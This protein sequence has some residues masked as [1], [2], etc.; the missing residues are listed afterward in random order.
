MA[1]AGAAWGAY[2]LVGRS[3]RD[4]IVA[5][6]RGFLW[7]TALALPIVAIGLGSAVASVEGVVL[8]VVCGAITS[9]LGY[10]VWYRALPRLTVMQ[11]AVVQLSV[12]V[13]AAAG[14]ALF[15]GEQLGSRFAV[16]AA[17]VLGGVALVTLS[18]SRR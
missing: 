8:A 2:S 9:A 15:L 3:A 16:S 14:A 4:P 13:L 11:A 10:A 12:P 6:A 17:A 18:G 1:V 5:N 7:A